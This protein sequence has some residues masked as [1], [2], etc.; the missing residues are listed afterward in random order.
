MKWMVLP[1]L[2]YTEFSGR[3]RRR[4]F[5]MFMLLYALVMIAGFG[6]MVVG[7]GSGSNG[8]LSVFSWAGI[9]L[10]G[11]WWLGTFLPCISLSVRRL[12]DRD[13]PGAL[14]LVFAFGWLLPLAG[15]FAVIGYFVVMLLPGMPGENRYGPDPKGGE[16]LAEVFA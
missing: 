8:A 5:G 7:I 16:S 9:A 1:L 14:S 12:H 10:I 15:M 13:W 4:E 2:R 11:A 3:S 6:L